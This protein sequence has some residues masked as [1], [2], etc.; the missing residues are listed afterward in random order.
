MSNVSKSTLKNNNSDHSSNVSV[1]LTESFLLYMESIKKPKVKNEEASVST[2]TPDLYA[3]VKPKKNVPSEPD[4]TKRIDLISAEVS[5]IVRWM[6]GDR[7]VKAITASEIGS[8]SR[9]HYAESFSDDA[10]ER[11]AIVKRF[12]SFLKKR[13]YSESNLS[14]HLRSRKLQISRSSRETYQQRDIWLTRDGYNGMVSELESLKKQRSTI[15]NDISK[16]A[17]DGDVRENAPLAAARE[18]HALVTSR[19]RDIE[20]TL[21]SSRIVSDIVNESVSVGTKVTLTEVK[22][23]RTNNLQIVEPNEASPLKGKIST[24]SPVGSAVL[25]RRVGE[26]VKVS[27][28]RGDQIYRVDAIY[29]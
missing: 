1:T 18:N 27:T 12:L 28:P 25:N 26:E 8:F 17:A 29:S 7:D 21:R 15:A 11:I 23:G 19:I 6:G 16:A 2:K 10:N 4:D 14:V 9:D 22:S 24:V 20:A 3:I 5:K 13:G